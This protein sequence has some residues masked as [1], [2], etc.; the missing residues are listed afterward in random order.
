MLLRAGMLPLPVVRL[1]SDLGVRYKSSKVSLKDAL[2]FEFLGVDLED[3]G[4]GFMLPTNIGDLGLDL[5]KLNLSQCNLTGKI[6][7]IL[8]NYAFLSLVGN[9]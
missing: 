2:C 1:F 9:K 4:S 3:A 7:H 8:P 6:Y 5:S